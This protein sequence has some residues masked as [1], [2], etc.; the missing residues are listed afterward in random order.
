MKVSRIKAEKNKINK[1]M[2]ELE[3]YINA[4]CKDIEKMNASVW[5]GGDSA[6]KW[7]E[8]ANTAYKKDV[9]FFNNKTKLLN[10]LKKH[11]AGLEKL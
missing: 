9:N 6:N 5:Y 1:A 11:I 7:Y 2:N 4:L 10:R 3:T 8:K